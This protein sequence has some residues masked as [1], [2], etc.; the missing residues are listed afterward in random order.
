MRMRLRRAEKKKQNSSE[1]QPPSAGELSQ[2]DASPGP[3]PAAKRRHTQPRIVRSPDSTEHAEVEE[4]T[5]N[6]ELGDIFQTQVEDGYDNGDANEPIPP[7]QP[8]S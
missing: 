2:S 5:D 6:D 4:N 3:R 7:P 8:N 1:D